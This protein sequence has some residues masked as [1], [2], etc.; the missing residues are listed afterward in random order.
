MTLNIRTESTTPE[1]ITLFVEGR[2]DAS[3]Y[4]P[5]DSEVQTKLAPLPEGGTV[6][7]D[8][9]DLEY[10]SSAGLRSFAKIRKQMRARN[11]H[12]LLLNPQPQVRKVFD[13]VKAVPVN[14]IFVT[15]R[16]L[17]DYLD[18]IQRKMMQ[19]DR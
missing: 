2:L 19:E 13:I 5:F 17:D 16:E 12:T 14:E 8:L 10:I 4:G 11:G 18:Q 7:L 1:R 15:V 6:V 3:N 9:K